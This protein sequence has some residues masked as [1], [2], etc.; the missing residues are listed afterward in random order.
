MKKCFATVCFAAAVIGGCGGPTGVEPDYGAVA[1]D[2][3]YAFSIAMFAE[4]AG[5]F[6]PSAGDF[7]LYVADGQYSFGDG[8]YPSAD[9]DALG[10]FA[11]LQKAYEANVKEIVLFP[12]GKERPGVQ[13]KCTRSTSCGEGT[14]NLCGKE[15]GFKKPESAR[16]YTCAAW[17]GG[18]LG[19]HGI[20]ESLREE[21]V[22]QIRVSSGDSFGISA[23]YSARFEDY[24]V[25]VFLGGLD[26]DVDALGN[27]NFDGTLPYLQAMISR[28]KYSYV[29][30]NLTNATQTLRGIAPYALYDV[31]NGSG[32]PLRVAFVGAVE[33]TI[34][35]TVFPGKFGS[36]GTADDYCPIVHAIERA[37]NQNARAFFILAHMGSADIV[38]TLMAFG[39]PG[40]EAEHCASMLEIPAERLEKV[41]G[42][43]SVDSLDLSDPAVLGKYRTLIWEIRSE[44]YGQIIG[45]LGDANSAGVYSF[46]AENRADVSA[47]GDCGLFSYADDDTATPMSPVAQIPVCYGQQLT[48]GTFQANYRAKVNVL[49]SAKCARDCGHGSSGMCTEVAFDGCYADGNRHPIHYFTLGSGGENTGV[50]RVRA[51]RVDDGNPVSDK[52]AARYVV[53]PESYGVYRNVMASAL[54]TAS[55]PK[56]KA[57]VLDVDPTAPTPDECSSYF[58]ANAE[59]LGIE[60]CARYYDVEKAVSD[61]QS[62]DEVGDAQRRDLDGCLAQLD[63]LRESTGMSS[64]DA[65]AHLSATWACVYK[66]TVSFVC[67]PESAENDTAAEFAESIIISFDPPMLAKSGS[68]GE[69][70]NHEYVESTPRTNFFVELLLNLVN[71]EADS[72]YDFSLYNAGAFRGGDIGNVKQSDIDSMAVFD[73]TI[74]P[75]TITPSGTVR[76]I[77]LPLYQ[78]LT[79]AVADYGGFPILSRMSFSYRRLNEGSQFTGV[80]IEEVW[81]VTRSGAL[82]EPVYVRTDEEGKPECMKD[83]RCVFAK[84]EVDGDALHAHDVADWAW[85]QTADGAKHQLAGWRLD[86]PV[87]RGQMEYRFQSLGG[88]DAKVHY[89]ARRDAETGEEARYSFLTL[90]YIQTGGDYYDFGSASFGSP[91]TE[92][93]LKYALSKY[94]RGQRNDDAGAS[95]CR[96]EKAQYS[97]TIDG[98]DSRHFWCISNE[99]HAFNVDDTKNDSL[100]ID[101]SMHVDIDPSRY[102]DDIYLKREAC[103]SFL[104]D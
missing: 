84:Y 37:Y 57:T 17:R 54:E 1:R 74:V 98:L 31:H 65:L 80:V 7:A 38:P 21:N 30:S 8:V 71:H 81:K 18:A 101:D 46:V 69:P 96:A 26:F 52:R 83:E 68:P 92:Y 99:K 22:P 2:G 10:E 56:S 14:G 87:V 53:E 93:R 50:L 60:A 100:F 9:F 103:F 85:V 51:K 42:V 72:P 97:A 23:D 64:K 62:Y 86:I 89:V 58:S 73:N 94:L 75:G 19:L 88:K 76:A 91:F 3:E 12:L 25:P 15:L 82:I 102:G 63:G 78:A 33:K 11:S 28:S 67:R 77:T 49:D 48:D 24:P 6:L 66:S 39:D 104:A 29:V 35:S 36:L 70:K 34:I 41:F 55:D 20:W 59:K 5:N 90:D 16:E 45:F 95:D 4:L 43:S 13:L 61:V 47:R 79:E 40:Y 44:I 27:H 32:T